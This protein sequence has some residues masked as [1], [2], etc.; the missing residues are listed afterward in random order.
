MNWKPKNPHF[1]LDDWGNVVVFDTHKPSRD[2]VTF[3]KAVNATL[4]QV[5]KKLRKHAVPV[6][7]STLEGA[8]YRDNQTAAE[9][10][11]TAKEKQ[12]KVELIDGG[13]GYSLKELLEI[14]EHEL[15]RDCFRVLPE[16]DEGGEEMTEHPWEP[17][18]PSHF[19]CVCWGEGVREGQLKLV[20]WLCE[21]LANN[22][23]SNEV[24]ALLERLAEVKAALE[25][26]A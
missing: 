21:P 12:M 14:L 16:P 20:E 18:Q 13:H 3:D 1:W 5:A 19:V 6:S 25:K 24:G 9:L 7:E 10:E 11:K 22:E 17:K 8:W 2:R 4:L 15:P 23:K 26:K